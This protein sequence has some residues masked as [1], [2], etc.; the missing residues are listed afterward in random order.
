MY[1]H[2]LDLVA[3]WIVDP[4]LPVK[5][6]CGLWLLVDLYADRSEMLDVLKEI[7]SLYAEVVEAS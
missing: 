5:V 6:S 3:V 7:V 4:G 2:E 1:H